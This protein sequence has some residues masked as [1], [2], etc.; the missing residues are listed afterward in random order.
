GELEV[1]AVITLGEEIVCG[2]ADPFRTLSLR[3]DSCE[4]DDL[5]TQNDV[6][7]VHTHAAARLFKGMAIGEVHP[8]LPI[9][10]G[11]LKGFGQ[12]DQVCDCI[13]CAGN[14]IDD[15]YRMLRVDEHFC[16]LGNGCR[17][18]C[19]RHEFAQLWDAQVRV[20]FDFLFL[21]VHIE[22][23]RYRHHRW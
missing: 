12:F 16:N 8:A 6:G 19:W 9:D 11:A 3:P 10:H 20:F 17:I 13:G 22:H 7:I 21:K 2:D 18:C 5:D 4:V 15:D 1:V 14:A 23:N